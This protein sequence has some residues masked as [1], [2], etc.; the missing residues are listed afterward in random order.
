[1]GGAYDAI[2]AGMW[3]YTHAAFRVTTFGPARLELA[4]GTLLVATHRRETDVPVLSPP[5]YRRAGLWRRRGSLER[6]SF[7]ARP[8]LLL[9]GFLAGVPPSLPPLARRLLY[10]VDA[11]GILARNHVYALWSA[12][13]AR[14]GE[15]L[16]ERADVPLEDLLPPEFEQQFRERAA[17]CGLGPP[18]S[19]RDV[20]RGEYADLLWLLVSAADLRQA[21]LD[22]FWS[23]RAA[24]A[25]ADFR[26]LVELLR[27]GGILLVFPE[28][29]PSPHGEI[30]PLQRGLAALVRRARPA[31]LRPIAL[32]YDPLT[33]GRTRV[34]LSIGEAVDAPAT[35][36]EASVLALLRRT[37][38]L[39]CGQLV[40]DALERGR[41][42]ARELESLVA[43]AVETARAERRS[44]DPDIVD[45]ERR[46]RRIADALAAAGSRP[47]A[48]AYLAREYRSARGS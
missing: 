10:P 36:I 3:L 12:T 24:A 19:A 4:P 33:R 32:A 40:A 42:S 28:G 1:M 37:M 46:S 39:T 22:A 20:L 48:L 44:V 2:A 43:T 38:P 27:A 13:R 8:D 16:R 31:A 14:L 26:T 47:D 35:E 9:P 41:P 15:V 45:G 5:L 34:L 6:V 23:R 7:A 18:T 17:A 11:G 29:R 21:G 25:A 30:G